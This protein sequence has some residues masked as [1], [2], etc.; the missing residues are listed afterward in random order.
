MARPR[1]YR[2][3]LMVSQQPVDPELIPRALV[4][5]VQVCTRSCRLACRSSH[6]TGGLIEHHGLHCRSCKPMFLL[7]R[8][9]TVPPYTQD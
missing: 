4:E 8:V 2:N 9:C 6:N 7:G 1:Y 5:G 3:D